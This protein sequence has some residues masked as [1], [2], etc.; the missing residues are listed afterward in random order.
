MSTIKNILSETET[1]QA[2]CYHPAGDSFPTTARFDNVIDL[3]QNEVLIVSCLM[4]WTVGEVHSC[5]HVRSGSY[6]PSFPH[7]PL[8]LLTLTLVRH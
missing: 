6:K 7:Q 4:L 5:S 1:K 3:L 2:H 8:F